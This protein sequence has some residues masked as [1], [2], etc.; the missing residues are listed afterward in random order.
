MKSVKSTIAAAAL[1][2]GLTFAVSG[3]AAASTL[4]PITPTTHYTYL[5]PDLIR[6]EADGSDTYFCAVGTIVYAVVDLP[7]GKGCAYVRELSDTAHNTR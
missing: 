2:T 7:A 4:S 1:V 3:S 5:G 6:V